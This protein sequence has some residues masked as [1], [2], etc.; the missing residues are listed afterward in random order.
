MTLRSVSIWKTLQQHRVQQPFLLPSQQIDLRNRITDPQNEKYFHQ[1]T[2]EYDS[3]ELDESIMSKALSLSG[4]DEEKAKWKYIELR[5]ERLS[6]DSNVNVKEEEEEEEEE[7][8]EEKKESSP[9]KSFLSIFS[10][11]EDKKKK[12]EEEEKKKKE[13]EEKKKEEEEKKGT[14]GWKIF[15]IILFFPITI[16]YYLIKNGFFI[17]WWSGD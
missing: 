17:F 16:P 7:K 5:A 2:D 3:N 6:E 15:F 13:E 14:S 10:D 1:A 12:E 9:I 11:D 4:G 8:E